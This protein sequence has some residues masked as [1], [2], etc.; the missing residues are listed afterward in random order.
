MKKIIIPVLIA[1]IF[2]S[3]EDVID[4]EL[5]EQDTGLYAVEAKITTIDQPFVYLTKGVPVTV[6]ENFTGISHALVTISDDAD[7]QNSIILTEDPD[8][9]GFYTVSS[10]EN[11]PGVPGREYTVTIETE[12][13][14]LTASD[15][16]YSVEKIDSIN[17]WPS[18]RGDKMF[19]GIFTYGYETPGLGNYYKWDIFI[20]DTLLSDAEMMSIAS[21]EFVDGNYINGLEI[22]TDFYNPHNPEERKLCYLDTI[23]VRQNSLSSFA[24]NYFYQLINQ[25]YGGGLFSVPPA[26][27]ES[28]FQSNDGKKVLGLFTA[29]D[30]SVSNRV[31][32]DDEIE[33]QLAR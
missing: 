21:D 3:C 8:S 19:L 27:I 17:V 15:F 23:Q 4:V 7:P 10:G 14:I 2:A 31:I 1:F 32:I 18:L 25:S 30:V 12:G 13:I 9:A 5:N 33:N 16:L 11:F 20:N 29:H 22:F 28:N 26:N 6:D 24:Y